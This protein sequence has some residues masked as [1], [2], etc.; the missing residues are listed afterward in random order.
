MLLHQIVATAKLIT[1]TQRIDH[2]H[3]AIEACQSVFKI[4]LAHL[5]NRA[6][7]LSDRF[8][9]ANAACLNRDVVE[10]IHASDVVKLLDEVHFQRAADATI[11]ESYKT[12]VFFAYHASLFNQVGIN[13][14]FANIVY[15]HGK[16]NATVVVQNSVEKSG[17]ATAKIAC[18]Q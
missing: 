3:D 14:H 11:L 6:D 4:F 17:L 12:I 5:W 18:N 1:H 8:G 16:L 10:L 13:V 9:F 7:G 15:N 2:G